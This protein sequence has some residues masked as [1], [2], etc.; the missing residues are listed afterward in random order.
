MAHPVLPLAPRRPVPADL[1]GHCFNYLR[2]DHVAVEWSYAPRCLCCHREGH[3]A[4]VSK[5]PRL[6]EVTGPQPHLQRPS[7]VVLNPRSGDVALAKQATF[8]AP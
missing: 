7:V 2:T 6:P 8:P 5:W 3:Q 4:H 1:V